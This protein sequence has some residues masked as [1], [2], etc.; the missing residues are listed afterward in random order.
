[1]SNAQK[2]KPTI[3]EKDLTV[4]AAAF[5]AA[6][7]QAKKK[8]SETPKNTVTSKEAENDK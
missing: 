6:M 5:E 4:M 3:A 7:A 8:S 2:V 1:M